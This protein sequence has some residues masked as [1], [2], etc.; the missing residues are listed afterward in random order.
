ML[1]AAQRRLVES[2]QFDFDG[3]VEAARAGWIFAHDDSQYQRWK[4]ATPKAHSAPLNDRAL[5]LAIMNI[6]RQFPDNVVFG[7]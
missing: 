5:E 4:H 1:D 7:R 3:Q 2:A 6:A